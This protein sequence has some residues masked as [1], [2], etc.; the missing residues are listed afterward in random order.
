MVKQTCPH[1]GGT[2]EKIDFKEIAG[3]RNEKG[4]TLREVSAKMGISLQYL[5][6]LEHG[7][8]NWDAELLNA[9]NKALA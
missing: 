5:S 6:D 1:C 8:R 2:G 3:R 7:R 9:F 4:L